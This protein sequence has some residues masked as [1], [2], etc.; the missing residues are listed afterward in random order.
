M[1]YYCG[2]CVLWASSKDVDRYGRRWCSYSKRYEEANQ[3]IYGCRGFIYRGRTVLTKVCEILHLDTE[4][5]F[6]A[7]DGVKEAFV[8]P[9]HMEWL[10]DY[11]HS[12]PEIAEQLDADEHRDEV[13]GELMEQ[14]IKPAYALWEKGEN[15]QSAL[16]YKEMIAHLTG[17]YFPKCCACSRA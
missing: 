13:A 9:N 3:N 15:E 14:Y 17:V 7:F 16:K 11:C 6:A 4:K 2:E 12:G 8:A 5:W 10:T 1:A